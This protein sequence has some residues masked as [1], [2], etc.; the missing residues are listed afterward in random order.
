MSDSFTARIVTANHWRVPIWRPRMSKI[1]ELMSSANADWFGNQELEEFPERE[2]L[3]LVEPAGTYRVWSDKSNITIMG[4]GDK[5]SPLWH[6][7]YS[8]PADNRSRYHQAVKLR[9][10]AT[11]VVVLAINCH[12]AN[13]SRW[14][15]ARSAH[16]LA[17]V[18]T[19]AKLTA[20]GTITADT[21][22][23]LT[24]DFNDSRRANS[25]GS[26]AQIFKAAGL[27]D[28]RDVIG[29]TARIDLV[30]GRNV[31]FTAWSII[32]TGIASD[33]NW[34]SVTAT[35]PAG[36]PQPPEPAAEVRLHGADV[37][38]YQPGWTPATGDEFAMV[39]ASQGT[40]YR[41]PEARAQLD[42][43]RAD[44]LAV[45]HYHY[46]EKGKP[47]AQAA[48]FVAS[49][50]IRRGDTLWCDWEGSWSAGKHPSV[51]DAAAFIAEVKRL[52][53]RNKVGLYCNRSDWM[54]TS[55]K[56]GDGLWI[57]EYGVKKP[58]TKTDWVFWQYADHTATGKS[59]DQN[60]SRF[61]SRA[62]LDAWRMEFDPEPGDEPP[63]ELAP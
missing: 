59:L 21:P 40:G 12:M 13:G 49:A 11:G 31:T 39:K 63:A 58:N 61:T 27:I 43:A 20:L 5:F 3:R 53:P 52:R 28:S 15:A 29:V 1:V 36:P 26:P 57:A 34:T 8:V 54:T 6:S 50:D 18:A 47:E 46:L 56:A 16:A 25:A 22:I 48:H 17:I 10:D 45:G 32:K 37:S 33:H 19:I 44:G 4:R 51:E 30:Y 42:G 2:A 7:E 60:W 55:V 62:E 23:V 35:I 9:H 14:A 24:G 38:S 41:N